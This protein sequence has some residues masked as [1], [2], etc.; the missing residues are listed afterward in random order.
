MKW[1]IRSGKSDVDL[2]TTNPASTQLSAGF[3]YISYIKIY[4]DLSLLSP[5]TANMNV[6]SKRQTRKRPAARSPSPLQAADMSLGYAPSLDLSLA[7]S[8]MPFTL[9]SQSAAMFPDAD[10]DHDRDF[11]AF[12]TFYSQNDQSNQN[13]SQHQNHNHSQQQQDGQ[14][15]A[16]LSSTLRPGATDVFSA[17]HSSYQSAV[18]PPAMSTGHDLY[19]LDRSEQRP[20]FHHYQPPFQQQQY[21]QQ[22]QQKQQPPEQQQKQ[23]QSPQQGRQERPSNNPTFNFTPSSY[24]LDSHMHLSET[25]YSHSQSQSTS[26]SNPPSAMLPLEQQ[27]PQQQKHVNPSHVLSYSNY[28]KSLGGSTDQDRDDEGDL[29]LSLEWDEQ[30]QLHQRRNLGSRGSIGTTASKMEGL[31]SFD[32]IAATNAGS[33]ADHYQSHDSNNNS[34]LA[35]S[36]QSNPHIGANSHQG[37]LLSMSMPGALP[38]SISQPQNSNG[39]FS[40]GSAPFDEWMP[41]S[42][43]MSPPSGYDLPLHVSSTSAAHGGHGHSMSSFSDMQRDDT[44]GRRQKIARTTFSPL[45]LLKQQQQQHQNQNQQQQQQSSPRP[46]GSSH[47]VGSPLSSRPQSHASSPKPSTPNRNSQP[48]RSSANPNPSSSSASPTCTNCFTQTTP[49][50]R[51]NPEGQPLCNACGLFLKLHGVV[52][53]L[54]LKTDV[55]KKRNRG[56]NNGGGTGNGGNGNAPVGGEAVQ[57]SGSGTGSTRGRK[58]RKASIATGVAGLDIFNGVPGSSNANS[59]VDVAASNKQNSM[60]ATSMGVVPIAAAPSKQQ[61]EQQ[62]QQHSVSTSSVPL[63]TG[64]RVLPRRTRRMN[65]ISSGLST[66]KQ[67]H[68]AP[69]SAAYPHTQSQR[70]GTQQHQ[71]QQQLQAQFQQASPLTMQSYNSFTQN[72]A[73]AHTS[74]GRVSLAAFPQST[75]PSFSHSNP[76]SRPTTSSATGSGL[77]MGMSLPSM[78]MNHNPYQ[79]HFL[80]QH[81]R[82]S[83]IDAISSYLHTPHQPPSTQDMNILLSQAN[84]VP[85][86]PEIPNNQSTNLPVGVTSHH[87]PG[88]GHDLQQWEWLTMSL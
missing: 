38:F 8:S 33:S 28:Q 66:P 24:P 13:Q 6:P 59:S 50:W 75:S 15:N 19:T 61:Q 51:R 18:S 78:A 86:P 9:D 83:S 79:Q 77:S 40:P 62:H 36:S 16:A 7:S 68:I 12:T 21:E 55:I 27:P 63:N 17:A 39:V 87:A 37:E 54:S 26:R 80:A 84:S 74:P 88:D 52:R 35:S 31:F 32:D 29:D 76:S 44:S 53:P 4:I 30:Q 64:N 3:I 60:A 70:P 73:S 11:Q 56:G 22:E 2:C 41:S 34:W 20:E 58:S 85:A 47:S 82:H 14:D 23:H 10:V 45:N 46:S 69:S 5:R 57:D 1:T 49:L 65:S 72:G 48:S 42:Q 25:I 43:L 71:Q 67:R 81:P